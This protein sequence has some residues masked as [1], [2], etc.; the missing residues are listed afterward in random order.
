MDHERTLFGLGLP[1]TV[2]ELGWASDCHAPAH[3]LTIHSQPLSCD[4][5]GM[6]D[7]AHQSGLVNTVTA[8]IR[9]FG[10]A[11]FPCTGCPPPNGCSIVEPSFSIYR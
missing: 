10:H 3:R 6:A 2:E 11:H 1:D 9:G 4:R 7:A 8:A 5:P